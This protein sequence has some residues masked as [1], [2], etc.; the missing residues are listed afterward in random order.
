MKA[1]GSAALMLL[2]T[3]GANNP[4]MAG[5]F[6]VGV[7]GGG[8]LGPTARHLLSIPSSRRWV[9]QPQGP[10]EVRGAIAG[11]TLGYNYQTGPWV[12]GIESFKINLFEVRCGS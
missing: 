3:T 2:A 12:L 7:N 8:G 5:G 1:L 11:A 6:Y 4:A 10:H 9:Y